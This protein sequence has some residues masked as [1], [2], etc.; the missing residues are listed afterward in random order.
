[1][2]LIHIK[3]VF[4]FRVLFRPDATVLERTMAQT[5]IT[6]LERRYA[7]LESEIADALSQSPTDDLAIADLMYRKLIIADEIQ[8]NHLLVERTPLAWGARKQP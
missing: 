6:Y 1:M 8:H 4:A 2:P 5:T 3:G 7:A